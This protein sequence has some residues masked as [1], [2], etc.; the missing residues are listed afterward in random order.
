MG[1]VSV[2][3]PDIH[4]GNMI[5]AYLD[6]SK[7]S[8][9]DLARFLNM[10]SSNL[11][12]L[13]KRS[14]METKRLLEICNKLNHNFFAEFCGD[15]DHA[16]QGYYG[17]PLS[18]NLGM[19]IEKRLVDLQMSRT[20]FANLIGSP[21][22][23]IARILKKES[24][25]TERLVQISRLLNYNFFSCFYDPVDDPILPRFVRLSQIGLEEENKGLRQ[26]IDNLRG[27]VSYLEQKLKEAGIEY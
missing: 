12:R 25:E 15:S 23:D 18:V 19:E 5:I 26:Q 16:K 2:F 10:S 8:Q 27:R 20:D 3:I 7:Y 1:G 6:D 14:S 11:S 21:R 17:M 4:V 9:A 24:F 13:L 22:S